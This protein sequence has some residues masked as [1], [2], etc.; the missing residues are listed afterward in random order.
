MLK[1]RK[2]PRLVGLNLNGGLGNQLFQYAAG[3][4]LAEKFGAELRCDAYEYRKP[5]FRALGL[6]EFGVTWTECRTPRP[7]GALRAIGRWFGADFRNPFRRA[8]FFSEAYG[9]FDPTIE[10]LPMPCFLHGYFQSWRY[11]AG[12][13][14]SV[15]RALDIGK[16]AND[17][18]APFEAA[19][20]A[21]RNPVAVHVRRGDY[22]TNPG[23]AEIYSQ[24]KADYY[25][26]A[27]QRL[28]ESV[29]E[30]T[31]FLFSDEPATAAAELGDW[32]NLIPCGG[33]SAHE[34]LMLMALCDHFI[35]ANSTF[36]WWG[37]WLGRSPE[38]RVV[39][40]ENWFNPAHAHMAEL[41]DL[42]PAGWMM[43]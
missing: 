26:R 15:R 7:R 32:P 10:Q 21:A 14:A 33:L 31:F 2:D 37:A 20:R 12:H 25:N 9:R 34:D 17:R 41:S 28:E 8:A 16:I 24:L 35:I 1:K 23:A 43:V 42:Y 27:R 39:A 13:E 40:P 11:F 18:T 30:P 36:S 6:R 38:K 19:I 29:S 3:L 5:G 4:A 22:I